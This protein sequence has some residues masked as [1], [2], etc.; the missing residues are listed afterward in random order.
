MTTLLLVRHGRTSANAK[1]I[2]AGD[3]AGVA[4]D[5]TG[6]NQAK[7]L[8]QQL[9]DVK[10]AALITS[11]LQRCQE[12]LA[13]LHEAGA[14]EP[15][16]EE[17]IVECGYGEWTGKPLEELAADPLWPAV[18]HYPSSVQFP[19]G[20]TMTQMQA[21]AVAAMHS[22]AATIAKRHGPEAVWLMCSHEDVIK[23]MLASLLGIHLDMFQRIVVAN[24]APCVVRLTP[25]RPYILR[26][27]DTSDD[28][29]ELLTT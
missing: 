16:I 1:R 12:T 23:S 13:P 9:R 25:A 6:H 29:S 10:L 3:M 21:R 24:S 20:E 18:Q 27:N 17:R 4:L 14:P 26:L 22:W 8:A 28:L 15:I 11:P 2:L 19:G 5:E 7:A